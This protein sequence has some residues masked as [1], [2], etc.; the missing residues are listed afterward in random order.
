[1]HCGG[2]A[3]CTRNGSKAGQEVRLLGA[4]ADWPRVETRLLTCLCDEADIS[5]RGRGGEGG[6]PPSSLPFGPGAFVVVRS[7]DTDWVFGGLTHTSKPCGLARRPL[8]INRSCVTTT[9]QRTR[10][11]L[12]L[13]FW[14]Q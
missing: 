14:V 8:P 6:G 2:V 12:V 4:T 1:M 5:G 9:D 11:A 10:C 7:F 3:S 13:G